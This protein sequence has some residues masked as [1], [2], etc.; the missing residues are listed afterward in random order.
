MRNR[1]RSET[2]RAENK[3]MRKA[4]FQVSFLKVSVEARPQSL[5]QARTV[6]TS[7]VHL[8]LTDGG[9]WRKSERMN[10]VISGCSPRDG[11]ARGKS[12]E[13]IAERCTPT[14]LQARFLTIAR[15]RR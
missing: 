10:L 12:K 6:A 8:G 13:D 14:V 2:L 1:V 9:L 3:A 7:H 4:S 11:E 15:Y 5:T